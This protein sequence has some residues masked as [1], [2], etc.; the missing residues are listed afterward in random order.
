[1][2]L[3]FSTKKLNKMFV[4]KIKGL[5]TI[6]DFCS[7]GG[8]TPPSAKAPKE[9]FDKIQER[10]PVRL[11]TLGKTRTVVVMSLCFRR[12]KLNNM[13]IKKI[14]RMSML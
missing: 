12:Q 3:C 5:N 4:K 13:F 14:Q 6:T 7:P 10:T 1:M 8:A 2:F 9:R 11:V